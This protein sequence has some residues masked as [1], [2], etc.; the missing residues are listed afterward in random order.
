MKKRKRA[1]IAADL[2]IIFVIAALYALTSGG[3]AVSTVSAL[4]AG[5]V[6]RGSSEDSVALEIAVSWD[7]N[8]VQDMLDTLKKYGV[9]ATFA[10]SG[11]YA[12]TQP[13]LAR[14]IA[15]EG[16]EIATMGF[17]PSF[18]GDAAAVRADIAESL[19]A[20]KKATDV[21]PVLYYSGE[22]ETAPSARAARRL[23]L[24][25]VLCT[26]DLRCAR[27]TA[28]D[29][30]KRG[31]NEPL[32]GSIILM[33]PTRAGADALAGLIEGFLAKGIRVT[34]VSAVTDPG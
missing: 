6:Y 5:P 30:M 21:S 2:F 26:L 10:L 9:H 13:A 18:D 11:E 24:T 14:R 25:H 19:A 12:Q 22:R 33:Q 32:A 28:E 29:I 31:L 16:H 17:D 8:A 15:D 20:I 1:G 4:Y 27:G 3:D 23:G 7:A 34:T